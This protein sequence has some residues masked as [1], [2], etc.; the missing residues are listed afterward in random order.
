MRFVLRPADRAFDIMPG[1]IL[2]E[3]RPDGVY[4]RVAMIEDGPHHWPEHG[5]ELSHKF[6][7]PSVSA[8]VLKTVCR[9]PRE[10]V[11]EGDLLIKVEGHRRYYQVA[12]QE[13]VW[14]QDGW[15]ET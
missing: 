7:M 5:W 4:T 6:P 12:R 14:P 11:A 2:V 3:Q 15:T 1:D 10:D 13:G 9:Y 8:N